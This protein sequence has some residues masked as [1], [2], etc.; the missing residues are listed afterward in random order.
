MLSTVLHKKSIICAC[1]FVVLLGFF[2][3]FFTIVFIN[4]AHV[5]LIEFIFCSFR[6]VGQFYHT[7]LVHMCLY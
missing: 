1:H 5:I 3:C 6:V 7:L 2:V 4:F